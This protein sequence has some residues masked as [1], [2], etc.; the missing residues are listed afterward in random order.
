MRAI[1]ERERAEGD[2]GDAPNIEVPT[3]TY[4]TGD[5]VAD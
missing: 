5:C 3:R 2:P 4:G 1:D